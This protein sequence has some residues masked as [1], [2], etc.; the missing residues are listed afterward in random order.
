MALLAPV[1]PAA[2]GV[3]GAPVSIRPLDPTDRHA[4]EFVL[5]HLSSES[6]YRRFLSGAPDLSGEARR[7]ADT[8]HWHH[9]TLIAFG[10]TPRAPIGVADYVRCDRFDLAELSISVADGWQRRGVGAALVDALRSRAVASGVRQFRATVMSENRGAL[11]LMA[12]LGTPRVINN[13]G[14]V[15]ELEIDL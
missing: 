3:R 6:R 1:A 10:S 8:D 2:P 12:R 11:A 4:L 14:D 5:H 13:F 7:L 15:L 9:E